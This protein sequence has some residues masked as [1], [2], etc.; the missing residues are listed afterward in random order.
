MCPNKILVLGEFL[1]GR[2]LI[3][4]LYDSFKEPLNYRTTRINQFFLNRI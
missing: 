4:I 3:N 2:I 1:A